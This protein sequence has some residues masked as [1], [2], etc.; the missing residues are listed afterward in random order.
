[1]SEPEHTLQNTRNTRARAAA[2]S[3]VERLVVEP[4]G[5]VHFSSRGRVVVIGGEEAQWLAARLQPP[6][7][8][9]ILLTEGDE[10][11]GVPTTS[12]GGRNLTI[13]GHLG[14]FT[15]ELGEKDRHNHQSLHTDMVLDLGAEP[16]IDTE[17]PP[18]GYWHFGRE[19]QDLDA[20]QLAVDG[21]VGTFEKPRYFAYDPAICAHAR[22]GQNGCRRCIDACPAEAIIS[23]G[24]QVEV[25][26]NLCQGG[27]ICA[28][29]CPTGAMRYAYPGPADTAER[30]R[31]LL[32][33]YLDAGGADPV[34][35]FIAETDVADLPPTPPNLLLVVLE[36]LASVGHEIWLAAI[37]WGARRVLL[38]DGGSVPDR[39]RAALDRQ[40]AFSHDLLRGLGLP[41][42]ALQAV[43]SHAIPVEQPPDTGITAGDAARFAAV[44]GKRQLAGLALDFLWG[45][46][47]TR[48]DSFAI[49][50]GAPYGRIQVDAERCTL[51]MSCT[52]VCPAQAVSA[53]DETPRLVF[54][55]ANCVQCSICANSCPERAITLEARYMADPE[56]RRQ[57]VVLYEEPPFCCVV[58]GKP[59]ATRRVIDNILAKLVGHAMFQSERARR[60]LQMCEDCRVVD[61]VQDSEAMQA[62]VFANSPH[63]TDS[64][65]PS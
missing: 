6:L 18:P 31:L 26:P 45:R 46:P 15:L 22:S 54:Y 49:L 38:V 61:A 36:E 60:R 40:I 9:E 14:A 50:P 4:T 5:V 27:G 39:A 52:S 8:A 44:D 47:G 21:M 56:Q 19:P 13:S 55:E 28:T 3:A 32:L 30:V 63:K 53:G 7:H 37:A 23:I 11:A 33:S 58:C 41:S 64:E 59:F 25:N 1:M 42:D 62:G 20:A 34:I 29:V 24:E 35:M 65:R 16:L 43:D 51:C 17:L 2:Q 48:P 10:D 12:L 57:P